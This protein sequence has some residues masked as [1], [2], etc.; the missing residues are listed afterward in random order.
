MKLVTCLLVLSLFSPVAEAQE[1]ATL[2]DVNVDNLEDVTDDFQEYFFE[3]LKQK[4]IQ[5]YERALVALDKCISLRPQEA[6]LYFEKGKNEAMLGNIIEAEN[7]YLKALQLKPNQ[8]DIMES[9]YDVYYA[10]QDFEKAI[11]LVTQLVQFDIRYKED[12]ARIYLR[13]GSFEKTI[14]LIDEL[15]E[16][17][18]KDA[19]RNQIRQQAI[20][21]S[22]GDIQE[23]ELLKQI[24][25]NP[26][27]EQN[28]LNLIYVYSEQ[29]KTQQAYETAQRLIKVN[30]K[31]EIVHM[32]LYKYYLESGDIKQAVSSLEKVLKSS[33]IEPKAKHSILND[34]LIFVDRNPEYEAE[35]EEAVALFAKEEDTNVNE[36]L[37][38]YYIKNK[39]TDKALSS[40]E[41]AY[42]KNPSDLG[43]LRNLLMLQLQAE[44]FEN[45]TKLSEE[46]LTL[47][48][49][50][51]LFYLVYGV[52]QNRLGAPKNAK[53]YLEM[54]LDYIV[55]DPKMTADFYSEL[56]R[57]YE[58]LG[59]AKKIEKYRTLINNLN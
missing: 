51:A 24:A 3:A 44:Q 50:Q 53:D 33:K 57:A 47:Y 39:E 55:D 42:K 41:N 13:K 25:A 35:L 12:L 29:G 45:A 48:P 58:L 34:F 31:T 43:V 27:N 21:L 11:D 18:G 30:P 9:L 46:A 10:R 26:A 20:A 15:D 14:S 19:Y 23:K 4:G 5:N 56:L 32:A 16:K 40:Y 7:N 36:E 37:G 28:Y 8:R 38:A 22:G 54:G 1:P 49:S 2:K 6:I 59:D 52:A 17:L